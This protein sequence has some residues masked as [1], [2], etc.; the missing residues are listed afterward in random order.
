MIDHSSKLNLFESQGFLTFHSKSLLPFFHNYCHQWVSQ[1]LAFKLP[2]DLSTLHQIDIDQDLYSSS[3]SQSNRH[4]KDLDA[5][6]SIINAFDL[7]PF[8]SF[9]FPNGWD[10]WDEGFGSLGLRLVR[11]LSNDGY[12]WSMKA[13]GPASNVLSVSFCIFSSDSKSSL[14]IIPASHLLSDIPFTKESSIH[15]KDELRL[16]SHRFNTSDSLTP[17][18]QQGDLILMHPRLLHTEKNF[19]LSSTRLSLEF[20]ISPS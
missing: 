19:S 8:F 4:R 7:A 2:S 20:R 14:S 17:C 15:C 5:I 1:I 6:Y 3:L 13:W 11:P 9:H 12:D 18:G 16:D 10:I